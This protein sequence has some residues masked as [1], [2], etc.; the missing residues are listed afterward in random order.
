MSTILTTCGIANAYDSEERAMGWYYYLT[1]TVSFP[2]SAECIAVNKRNPLE[3]SEKVT[4]LQISSAD[5]CE[6]EIYVDVSWKDKILAIPLA[7]LNPL[8]ANEDSI[9]AIG[10]WHYWL[11]QGY[12]F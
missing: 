8:D 4:V 9:E 7:Q 11:E 1:D 5:Y 6:N 12:T 3:L 10:D 2:F